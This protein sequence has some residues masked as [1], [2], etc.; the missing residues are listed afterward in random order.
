MT[1]LSFQKTKAV[2]IIVLCFAV[3]S[4]WG[5]TAAITDQNPVIANDYPLAKKVNPF[6]GT[7]AHGHTYPGVCLPFGMVQLS[8]DTY[9]EGWDWC[10][11]YHYSDNSIMGFSHTHLSGT[12]CADYG[13]FL[14]MPTTGPVKTRPGSRENPEEGYRSR[15][16]H[17]QEK[18]CAGFYGVYLKDYDIDVQLTATMRVGVHQYT[19]P[20]DKQANVIINLAH[21]IGSTTILESKV[22]IV[23]DSEVRG[24]VR[25]NG[26]SPNRYLYFTARFSKPFVK[27]GLVID[28]TINESAKEAQ[29]K[30]LQCYVQFD[31]SKGREIIVKVALSA[32]SCDGAARNMDAECP[33][34]DFQKVCNDAMGD[35]QKQLSKLTVQGGSAANQTTFYTALYHSCLA[36]NLFMD[37]DGQYRGTDKKIHKAENFE[38]YTVFSLWDTFRA[39]HPLFTLIEQQRTASFV[40]SFLGKYDQGGLL[41]VWELASG[42]TW[43]MIGY[44]SVPVIMDAWAKGIRGFDA[45]KAFEAMKKSAT[46][47]Q[48]HPGIDEY[49][50]LGFVSTSGESESV[51]R[52]VEYAYDDWCIAQMAKDLGRQSDYELFTRRSQQYRNVFDRSVGFVRGKNSDCVW[53]PDFNPDQ[54]PADGAKEFTEGNSWHYTW[55][56]PHDVDGLIELMHGDQ[57]FIEKMDT[58]FV[59]KG[60]ELADVSGLIGQ[61]AH[62]NEPS[63]N[64]SYLYAYA[65]AP[66]KTQAMVSRIVKTLYS[67]KPDGLCGNEDCG[68]MSAWYVF[69]AMGFYPVCPGQPLYVFGT[70]LFA[71][72]SINLENGKTFRI[73]AENLSDNNIYI[74]S[75]TLN[76]KPYTRSYIQHT[77]ILNGGTLAFKMG[78][79]PNKQWGQKQ[80]DRPHSQPGK[81]MTLMPYPSGWKPVFADK[82]TIDLRCDEDAA[83]IY[84]T[85]D[86]SEPDSSATLYTRAFDVDKTT[87]IKARAYRDGYLP[88]TI[89]ITTVTKKT[90]KPAVE[91]E[92][93]ENGLNY[94]CFAGSYRKTSDFADTEPKERGRCENFDLSIAKQKDDFGLAFTGYFKAS[95]D[96]L[97]QF[98]TNSDDGSRLFIDS[99]LV[100]DNDGLHGAQSRDGLAALKQGYHEI[101]VLYFEGQVDETLEVS[102]KRPG[103]QRERIDS[104]SLFRRQ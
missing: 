104:Q 75:A 13:D 77:D 65:G 31:T 59:S 70:P 16:S 71:D 64:F 48:K 26:W 50:Q 87:T 19:Y 9:N 30:N 2:L 93:V 84:Y 20:A 94:A 57:A 92:R 85:Q 88:S 46:V 38:N 28:G 95:E 45:N 81:Q 53:K 96:G 72:L 10:S 33:G 63:H 21:Y 25:K 3:L 5:Q 79:Q 89:M 41:P 58:L 76:G 39:E 80:S 4:V 22:E 67:D 42:E 73:T 49:Q 1:N 56:A 102:V 35:W 8:P 55:F 12:G 34:W 43:C 86:G 90:L 62:G 11:G 18:A 82:L 29:A 98:W 14:F 24:F 60:R 36:P 97:Y 100:V 47:T 15:F 101:K 32:V 52:T 51:S 78:S 23:G 7:D 99:E 6:I 91:I 69:S 40:N 83:K 27:S 17:E 61:Y 37:V 54:L 44:H 74:Q 103:G 68:Q 66:W